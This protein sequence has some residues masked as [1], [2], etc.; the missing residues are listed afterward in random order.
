GLLLH[1]VSDKRFDIRGRFLAQDVERAETRELGRDR[2]LANPLAVDVGEEVVA[3]VDF[4]IEGGSI[5]TPGAEFHR[6]ERCALRILGGNR[7]RESQR[8]GGNAQREDASDHR[9]ERAFRQQATSTAAAAL[10]KI[11][12]VAPPRRARAPFVGYS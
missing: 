5:D 11:G 6:R 12:C 1:Q 10:C 7:K 3:W 2:V 4:R 8:G 9:A